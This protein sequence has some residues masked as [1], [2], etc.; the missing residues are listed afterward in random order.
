MFIIFTKKHPVGI[1]KGQCSKVS[2]QSAKEFLGENYAK[3]ISEDEY[4]EWSKA[5]AEEKEN[6][7]KGLLDESVKMS[8]AGKQ[9]ILDD[10]I[11]QLNDLKDFYSPS[12]LTIETS[13]NEFVKLHQSAGAAKNKKDNEAKEHK[14]SLESMYIEEL[15]AY[16]DENKLTVD[17]E[18]NATQ[19]DIVTLVLLTEE[20]KKKEGE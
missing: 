1:K 20:S 9:V 17:I 16:I 14:K 5:F 2:N 3:E 7:A 12:D 6:L 19:E 15:K 11:R 8:K 13:Q 10:R 4:N 18:E